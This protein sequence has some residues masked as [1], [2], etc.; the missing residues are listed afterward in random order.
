MATYNITKT[1]KGWT[2]TK[3][4]ELL[5]GHYQSEQAALMSLAFGLWRNITDDELITEDMV[6]KAV[7]KMSLSDIEP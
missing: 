5:A 2:I 4:G 1:R 6:A 3:D 7:A